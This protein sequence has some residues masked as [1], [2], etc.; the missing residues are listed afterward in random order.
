[1]HI[2]SP[3]PAG[4]PDH[5]KGPTQVL[6]VPSRHRPSSHRPRTG[7][8]PRPGAAAIALL[9]LGLGALPGCGSSKSAGTAADPAGAVPATAPVYVAATVRP[10]GSQK[11]AAL[12]TGRALTRQADPYLRLLALLQA[13]GAPALS[14]TRDVA[15]W[16]GPK[17]GIFLSS[18]GSSSQAQ[19]ALL[20]SLL[21]QGLLGESS[22]AGAFPFGTGR[23]QGAIVLDTT[24][25][26][27]ARSF[28]AS[29]AQHAGAHAAAYH[30]ASYQATA[31][32][33]AFGLVGSFAVIGSESAVHGVIDT[34][35][36]G[37]ALIHASGYARLLAVAPSGA[38]G[39]VYVG[40]AQSAAA[41]AGGTA[42]AGA[43]RQGAT[44]ITQLLV[45]TREANIS[46]VP[47]KGSLALDA[48]VL[49]PSAASAGG[50]GLLA[51]GV[52]G[53][54]AFSELPGDSWL[55][56]GLGHVAA[57]LGEDVQ[58]LRALA[59]L[60]TPASGS[61]GAAGA[62]LNIKGLLEGLLT[63]LAMLGG[64]S[65]QAKRDFASWMGSGGIF[66][67]GG[68]L[69]E[70]KGAVVITS[71]NPALSRAA[72]AK[73]AAQLRGNGSSVQPVSIAGTDAAVGARLTGLPLELIIADGRSSA[74]QTKFVLGL[75]E[76]SV[77]A[78]LNPSSTLAGA[79]S[80]GAAAATLGE[81]IQP[82]LIVDFPTVL[83]LLEGVGLTEGPT[84]SKVVP[85]LRSLTTL[86]GGARTLAGGVERVRVV[87]GLR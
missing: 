48:D 60:A 56:F 69:L 63:P 14:F 72:V 36:G 35:K 49:A 52:D 84:L 45:G 86:A 19:S 37:P 8:L 31:G 38:L 32:G 76:A 83:S 82:N 61:E 25:T 50:G 53:A 10:T 73:L 7:R 23:A 78:A 75:G 28:L 30:G 33:V 58:G 44:G 13:P 42:A 21:Q 12:S 55:A 68:S 77:A 6:R 79:A 22:S 15:P 47:A 2:R 29:E 43:A 57:T 5:Q 40:A 18:L 4:P 1:M 66:A 81:G 39:H 16:L 64:E 67:S 62:T 34:I 11:E 46:L 65:A 59:S 24:D 71:K 3:S 74:G 51:A 85:Y 54:Q 27:K 41:A 87:V 9:A 70:L 80:A 17:A 20:Q 26:A